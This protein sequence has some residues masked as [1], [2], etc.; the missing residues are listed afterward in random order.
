MNK[1]CDENTDEISFIEDYIDSLNAKSNTIRNSLN[2]RK[3][4]KKNTKKSIIAI[5]L[6]TIILETIILLGILP[7]LNLIPIIIVCTLIGIIAIEIPI[8]LLLIKDNKKIKECTKKLEELSYK[9]NKA[10]KRID[11]LSKNKTKDKEVKRR[12]SYNFDPQD[13]FIEKYLIEKRAREMTGG[14]KKVRKQQKKVP[15][16]FQI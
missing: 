5:P 8:A 9:K 11:I 13:Y 6:I 2:E 12:Y 10:R 3:K 4:G 14:K 7:P 16:L 15:A 1:Q